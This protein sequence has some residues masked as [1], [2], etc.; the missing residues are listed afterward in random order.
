LSSVFWIITKAKT[1]T[2]S[3]RS[4][5][6]KAWQGSYKGK[7]SKPLIVLEAVAGYGLFL[8]HAS[9][10]YNETLPFFFLSP[11]MS[12][13]TDRTFHQVEEEVGVILFEIMDEDFTKVF[14][15]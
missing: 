9:Y 8:C 12:G 3:L 1:T 5:C 7:E 2:T 10:G 6:P 4:S 15:C 14:S 11:L 13:L